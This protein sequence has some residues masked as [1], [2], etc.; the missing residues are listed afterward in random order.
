MQFVS[1][2]NEENWTSQYEVI[3]K[4]VTPYPKKASLLLCRGVFI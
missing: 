4:I 1:Y 2:M 3:V